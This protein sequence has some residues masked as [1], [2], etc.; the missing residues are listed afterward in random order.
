[1]L[2][3]AVLAVLSR[4]C[5]TAL[6]TGER[7]CCSVTFGS[8]FILC[9]GAALCFLLLDIFQPIL[10]GML[11]LCFLLVV[12]VLAGANRKTSLK[13]VFFLSSAWYSLPTD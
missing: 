11:G 2:M 5:E 4:Y 7:C 9:H 6:L 1:M 12:T 10:T 3:D 13:D 8:W